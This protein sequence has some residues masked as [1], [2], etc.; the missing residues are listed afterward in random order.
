MF[1][2]PTAA[3]FCTA[4]FPFAI[5]A[6]RHQYLMFSG[7]PM[8]FSFKRNVAVLFTKGLILLILVMTNE[9]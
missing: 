5:V 3:D 4:E 2:T 1:R 6:P 7:T 9:R 8:L